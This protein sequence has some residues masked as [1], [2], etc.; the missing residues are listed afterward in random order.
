MAI[1]AAQ[2]A[3]QIREGVRGIATALEVVERAETPVE[4]DANDVARRILS[5]PQFRKV[6]D[7]PSNWLKRA[8]D[9]LERAEPP[10]RNPPTEVSRAPT[11]VNLESL[12]YGIIV[13]LAIGAGVA[14]FL[15]ARS[16][17]G[18]SK[19]REATKKRKVGLLEE[20]EEAL[21]TDEWLARAD[22]LERSG[23]FREAVR[24]LY[25]AVLMRLDD[26]G[27]VHFDRYQ[28]NWEHLRRIEASQ[29]PSEVRYRRITQQFDHI[30]YGEL[31]ATS[32]H[33]AEF[34]REYMRLVET[35]ERG[36][37]R[38]GSTGGNPR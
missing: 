36:D 24:C 10:D 34:R 7:A 25:L 37:E 6:E 28:T 2:E 14:L 3:D 22:E 29:A 5:E 23:R 26:A 13:I 16:W 30:W 20:G 21:R 1:L 35:L 8:I 19:R 27:L 15:F 17:S 38:I 9:S 18:R 32:E 33:C 4:T 11:M 12:F 31:P